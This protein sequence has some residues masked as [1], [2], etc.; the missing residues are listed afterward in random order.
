MKKIELREEKIQEIIFLYNTSPLKPKDIAKE[1]G[2]STS[3]FYKVLHSNDIPMIRKKDIPTRLKGRAPANKINFSK[4]QVEEIITLYLSTPYSITDIAKHFSVSVKT[5]QRLLKNNEIRLEL[6]SQKLSNKL[7]GRIF[8]KEHCKKISLGKTGKRLIMKRPPMS[9][10]QKQNLREKATGRIVS[11]ETREKLSKAKLGRKDTEETIKNKKIAR[12]KLWYPSDFIG[13]LPRGALTKKSQQELKTCCKQRSLYKNLINRLLKTTCS[14]KEDLTK[15]LLGYT[16]KELITHIESQFIGEMSWENRN[17]F[18]VDHIIPIA[19]LIKLGITDPKIV[20]SL[21]NLQPLTPTENIIKNDNVSK[22][23][24]SYFLKNK[25]I[26][27]EF[28]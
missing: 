25:G 19:Q 14:C 27:Y 18:H 22:E 6:K 21:D 9:D 4:E 28:L 26:T 2:V 15:N 24:L 3:L 11:T 13:P 1:L 23:A 17:S 5:I 10:E 16:Q 7:K 12:Q 8:T 20:N